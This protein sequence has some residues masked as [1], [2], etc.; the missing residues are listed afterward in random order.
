[1]E[2]S[3]G[4]KVLYR[5]DGKLY[6]G[7]IKSICDDKVE[8]DDSTIEMVIA[9]ISKGTIADRLTFKNKKVI[10]GRWGKKMVDCD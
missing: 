10:D 3:I 1:M 4:D 8:I 5:K 9:A 7:I 6:E 2:L